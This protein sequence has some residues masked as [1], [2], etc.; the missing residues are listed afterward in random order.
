MSNTAP[1]TRI[2]KNT[3]LLY[4]RLIIVMLIS[5]YTVRVVLDTLGTEDYGI[6]N[7]VAGIV[8]MFGFLSG[9]MSLATQRF[10][11]LE[12][13]KGDSERLKLTF[14]AS[15]IIYLIITAIVVI[16]SE[17]AGL[18]FLNHK[19]TISP[20]RMNAAQWIYQ[21]SIVS[22][23][24]TLLATPYSAVV[25]AHEDMHIYAILSIIKSLLDLGIAFAL[26][27]IAW[28]KLKLYGTLLSIIPFVHFFIYKTICQY[29]Y[30]ECRGRPVFS[31]NILKEMI[32][33][34]GWMLFGPFSGVFKLQITNILLNQFF[35]P[36]I[37]VV[38]SIAVQ[39]N[40]AV[41]SFLAGFN[42][43]LRPSM[44]KNYAAGENDKLLL[45]IFLGTKGNF[46]LMY[47]FMLPIMLEMPMV[48]SLWLKNVPE[49]TVLFTRLILL[50][51][52]IDALAYPMNT[53]IMAGS[54]IKLYELLGE[55]ILLLNFPLSLLA[56]MLGKPAVSVMIIAIIV[57]FVAFILR[58]FIIKQTI[59]FPI[60][61]FLKNVLLPVCIAAATAAVFPV[62]I[63]FSIR[64][65][66]FRLFFSTGLSVASVC[67]SMYFAG[68]NK[69]ERG[70]L[71]KI[72]RKKLPFLCH[73]SRFG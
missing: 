69:L 35:S 41:S 49:H 7:V 62:L 30:N 48:L 50:E 55:G 9:T 22:F 72:V 73:G 52:L 56:L 11:S 51:T 12:M 67:G 64:Q 36:G 24:F 34:N 47:V 71:N 26:Q 33:Y 4:F 59:D 25:L 60:I 44:I 57:R 54:R 27:F 21:F 18:W 15:I 53:A 23:V 10:L 20:E 17:T 61:L 46:F 66:F 8:T 37:V 19:M 42:M 63:H 5:L 70:I 68:I 38:R 58:F 3:L 45:Q 16:M 43:A 29:K 39:V 14:S 13:G 32:V 65:G 40:N 2:A 31:G 6:Y 28:D 1:S